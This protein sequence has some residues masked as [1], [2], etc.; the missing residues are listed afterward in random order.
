M[1][2]EA[3]MLFQPGLNSG[4][5]V[6]GVIVRDQM[7][8]EVAGRLSIDLLEKAEPFDMRVACLGACDQLAGQLAEGSEQRDGAVP[9]IIVRH[10]GRALWRQGKAQLGAFERLALAFLIATQHQ[11]LG[12][13]IEVKPDHVP[14]LLLE[15]R[16]VREFEGPQTMRL[17]VVA[18]P[19]ALDRTGRNAGMT[20]HRTHAPAASALGRADRFGQH[21]RH[22]G[23]R[24]RRLATTTRLVGQSI[25][26]SYLETLGPCRDAFWVVFSC[27]AT[28]STPT[29]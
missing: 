17:E 20:A 10:R 25:Q 19:E 13:R 24:D 12:G 7:Q 8:V 18:R 9:D 27:S 6:S 14:E 2:V 3:W 22:F 28:P 5:F 15:L 23:R 4:V 1:H 11:R 29:P 26:A 21:A 16:I